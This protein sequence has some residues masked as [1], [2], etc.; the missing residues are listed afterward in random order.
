VTTCISYTANVIAHHSVLDEG[1]NF[2]EKPF[3]A[4]ALAANVRTALDGRRWKAD[5]AFVEPGTQVAVWTFTLRGASVS[6]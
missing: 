6:S 5:G 3:S 4:E 1:V 2:I